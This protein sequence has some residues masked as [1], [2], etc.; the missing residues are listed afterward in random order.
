MALDVTEKKTDKPDHIDGKAFRIKK[1]YAEKGLIYI[2]KIEGGTSVHSIKEI[3]ERLQAINE[4]PELN[5]TREDQQTRAKLN[6]WVLKAV[7]KARTQ[8]GRS[9][10]PESVKQLMSL[11]DRKF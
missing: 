8:L 10:M 5:L 6:D 7:M 11:P 2:E 4:A 9:S 3:L 1:I